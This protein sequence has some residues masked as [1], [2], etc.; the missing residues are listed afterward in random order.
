MEIAVMYNFNKR[1]MLEQLDRKVAKLSNLQSIE[2]SPKGWINSIRISLN[3]SLGQLAKRL[4][5]TISTVREIE[6]REENETITLKKL[7]E[8]AAS[9]DC[10]L[11]YGFIPKQGSFEKLLEVKSNELA[12]EIVLRASN[13]MMLEDQ[14][15]SPK[16][17]EKAIHDRA[18]KIKSEMPKYLWD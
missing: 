12:K 4:N 2:I 17:L 11:V 5:K 8:V 6:T 13:S 15:N 14:K 3:M 7:R 16:R 10:D 18:L 1:L 9:L